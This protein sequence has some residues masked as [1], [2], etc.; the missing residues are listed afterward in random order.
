MC[1]ST[2]LR[3]YKR[4]KQHWW[5]FIVDWGRG[6]MKSAFRYLSKYV[7]FMVTQWNSHIAPLNLNKWTDS[8]MHQYILFYWNKFSLWYK[9]KNCEKQ[10]MANVIFLKELAH[11]HREIFPGNGTNI[12]R[13]PVRF[14]VFN[15]FLWFT[16]FSIF[17]GILLQFTSEWHTD[18]DPS[19]KLCTNWGHHEYYVRMWTCPP[20]SGKHYTGHYLAWNKMFMLLTLILP[21]SPSGRARRCI[22]RGTP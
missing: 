2:D 3:L 14:V 10:N 15:P 12:I 21:P 22:Y 9:E 4:P 16:R 8:H 20:P 5:Q 17:G 13:V 1:C 6:E 18:H 11:Q 19:W 7:H